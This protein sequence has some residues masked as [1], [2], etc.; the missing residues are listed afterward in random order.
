MYDK[1]N[2]DMHFLSEWDKYAA[3]AETRQIMYDMYVWQILLRFFPFHIFHHIN[4]AILK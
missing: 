3:F 4:I 2:V 1:W